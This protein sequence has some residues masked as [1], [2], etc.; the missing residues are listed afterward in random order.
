MSAENPPTGELIRSPAMLLFRTLQ[1]D[2]SGVQADPVGDVHALVRDGVSWVEVYSST[3]WREVTRMDEMLPD[4]LGSPL[5]RP[6]PRLHQQQSIRD[7]G[8]TWPAM[9]LRDDVNHA[10][11]VVSD[12][13]MAAY[14]PSGG[15]P[16]R[17]A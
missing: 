13:M 3:H 10:V 8:V 16:D 5:P 14:W 2:F 12:P 15:W 4:E 7:L 1:E 9:T 6:F 11:I 17:A